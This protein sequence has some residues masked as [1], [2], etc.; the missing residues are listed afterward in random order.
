MEG[1]SGQVPF[2]VFW[3]GIVR[4]AGLLDIERVPALRVEKSLLL[5]VREGKSRCGL[6]VGLFVGLYVQLRVE[7]SLLLEVREGK[8]RCGSL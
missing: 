2:G 5:E 8:F 1:G 3:S 4:Q 6:F 7:K